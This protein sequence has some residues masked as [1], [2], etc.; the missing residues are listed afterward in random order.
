MDTL[1]WEHIHIFS[2]E[3]MRSGR[4][5]YEGSDIPLDNGIAS[6][7]VVKAAQIE[8]GIVADQYGKGEPCS[9]L[10]LLSWYIP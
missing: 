8:Q 10:Y 2:V 1:Q 5:C 7:L 9:N 4:L 6:G 3:G